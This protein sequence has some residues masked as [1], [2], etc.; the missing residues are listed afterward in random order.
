MRDIGRCLA[1]RPATVHGDALTGAG[2]RPIT[3]AMADPASSM[4]PLVFDRALL[5]RRMQRAFLQ[6]TADFLVERAAEDLQERLGAVLRPFPRVLDLGTPTP[7]V[8]RML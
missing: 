4:S 5:R 3:S 2:S 8:A 6:G 1:A 7:H